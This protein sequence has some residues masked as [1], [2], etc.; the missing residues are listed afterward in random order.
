MS[1]VYFTDLLNIK[2]N[3]KDLHDEIL[4]KSSKSKKLCLLLT[5][6]GVYNIL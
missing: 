2:K 4:L 3:Q 5:T 6:T 1:L